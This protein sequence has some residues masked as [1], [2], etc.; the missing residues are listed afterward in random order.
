MKF[1]YPT[2]GDY[3]STDLPRQILVSYIVH[4]T[5]GNMGSVV[6]SACLFSQGWKWEKIAHDFQAKWN[7]PRCIEAIDR[8]H[9]KVICPPNS[10][11][12]HFDLFTFCNIFLL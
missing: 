10:G 8:K 6:S 9:A 1:R 3:H 5:C 12:L 11:S 2:N 4:E 7:F